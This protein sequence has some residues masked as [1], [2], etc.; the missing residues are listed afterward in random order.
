[1]SIRN[2]LIPSILFTI[3]WI[4][5]IFYVAPESFF[6]EPPFL[7]IASFIVLITSYLRP[8]DMAVLTFFVLLGI[9]ITY[10]A[11]L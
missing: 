4:G 1:M 6:R 7:T 10:I 5:I 2:R 3:I 9:L 11:F 8:V